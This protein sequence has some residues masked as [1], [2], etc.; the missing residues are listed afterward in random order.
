M[1]AE[2]ERIEVLQEPERAGVLVPDCRFVGTL[3]D[4]L[5]Y[6]SPTTWSLILLWMAT[7]YALLA[8]DRRAEDR[9]V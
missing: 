6:Y 2:G 3:S 8:R 5:K 4:T 9:R 1:D 7:V